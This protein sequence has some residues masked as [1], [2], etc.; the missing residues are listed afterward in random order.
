MSFCVGCNK[1]SK[2]IAAKANKNNEFFMPIFKHNKNAPIIAIYYDH[3]NQRIARMYKAGTI[4]KDQV[5][6]YLEK[7]EYDPLVIAIWPDGEVI[8]SKQRLKGGKPY[9]K[10]KIKV[11]QLK[12]LLSELAKL[13]N[14]IGDRGH[15][16]SSAI[17]Y[18]EFS[19]FVVKTN[20]VSFDWSDPYYE[21]IFLENNIE[22]ECDPDYKEYIQYLAQRA[23]MAK[24]IF[25]YIPETSDIILDDKDV[26]I[27]ITDFNL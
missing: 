8:W 1:N 5:K 17:T 4:T 27:Q 7:F 13:K 23:S 20:K 21:H 26:E 12:Q 14:T 9:Y 16:P 11:N 22:P 24:L 6:E 19:Y 18:A 10:S 15:W 25:E 2:N 3:S